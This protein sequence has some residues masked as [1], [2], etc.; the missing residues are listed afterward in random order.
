MQHGDNYSRL[1]AEVGESLYDK[2]FHEPDLFEGKTIWVQDAGGQESWWEP[3][4][5]Q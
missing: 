1:M 4:W 3:R 2:I 5:I